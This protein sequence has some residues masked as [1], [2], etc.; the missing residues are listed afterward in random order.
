[1]PYFIFR[2]YHSIFLARTLIVDKVNLLKV[3]YMG[4]GNK[5][6]MR[7]LIDQLKGDEDEESFTR[8]FM[9]VLLEL[10]FTLPHL[11]QLIGGFFI[12]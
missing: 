6:Y 5:I 3:K 10:F 4:T 2:W 8:T 7:T 11:I 9:M 12:R 1:M